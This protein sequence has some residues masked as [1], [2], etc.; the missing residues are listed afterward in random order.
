MRDI[1]LL[2]R[3][4]AGKD[5]V[6]ARLVA[7]FGYTRL[8][9]ADPLKDMAVE[10]NPIVARDGIGEFRLAPL[11]NAYGWDRAKTEFPEVRRILQ[12]VGQGIRD[13]DPNYWVSVLQRNMRRLSGPIVVTD[14]RY[15]NEV[16]A[17]EDY[18][19]RA[20]RVIRPGI[21]EMNHSSETALEDFCAGVN[22]MN[23]GTLEDLRALADTLPF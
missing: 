3:A 7:R 2:G 11:V 17:L 4:Q 23:T 20:V 6:G 15:M 22:I 13:R 1:A 18:G 12:S 19:F 5:T 10:I 8:A 14:V 16:N 9:F 21:P